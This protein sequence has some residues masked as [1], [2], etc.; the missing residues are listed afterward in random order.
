LKKETERMPLTPRGEGEE[1]ISFPEEF[2]LRWGTYNVQRTMDTDNLFPMIAQ[3]L[4][5]Q[6]KDMRIGKEE[7]EEQK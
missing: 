2:P 1:I 7:A 4:P 5:E 3:G 6:W